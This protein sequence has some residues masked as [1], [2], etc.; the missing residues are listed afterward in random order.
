MKL[1][2]TLFCVNYRSYKIAFIGCCIKSQNASNGL[3]FYRIGVEIAKR[4]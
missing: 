3:I 2:A 4:F 1:P